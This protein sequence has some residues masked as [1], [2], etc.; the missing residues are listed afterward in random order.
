MGR[1]TNQHTSV[2][3]RHQLQINLRMHCS[4]KTICFSALCL[5]LRRV[6]CQTGVARK[7]MRL[8]SLFVPCYAFLNN[9]RRPWL[10]KQ[11][12]PQLLTKS[13]NVRFRN[14]KFAVQ[15]LFFNLAVIPSKAL[16]KKHHKTTRN[17]LHALL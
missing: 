10:E 12:F 2:V 3:K 15:A 11:L 6:T 5:Q 13:V 4:G 1:S 9:P 16:V 14:M 8:E 7:S 17:S